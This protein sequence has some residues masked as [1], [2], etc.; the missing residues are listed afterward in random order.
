M[1]A[2]RF[3]FNGSDKN[4]AKVK[5]YD[6]SFITMT[7]VNLYAELSLHFVALVEMELQQ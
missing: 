6:K 3:K 1:A 2:P 4:G 5:S 7:D